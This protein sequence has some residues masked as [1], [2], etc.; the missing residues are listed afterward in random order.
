MYGYWAARLFRA[1][2]TGKALFTIAAAHL[3]YAY[4]AE[5]RVGSP[6]PTDVRNKAGL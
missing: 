3:K 1:T 2:K 4:G 6:Q 5:G